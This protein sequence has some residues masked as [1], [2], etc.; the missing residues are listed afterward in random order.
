MPWG[1]RDREIG[2]LHGPKG[3]GGFRGPTVVRYDTVKVKG[4]RMALAVVRAHG[5]TF[6][7]M[8]EHGERLFHKLGNE[9]FRPSH[10]NGSVAFDVDHGCNWGHG[11]PWENREYPA[12]TW[13]YNI[14]EELRWL[15][16]QDPRE[17][18]TRHTVIRYHAD[19]CDNE[20]YEGSDEEEWT[21]R[22][23]VKPTVQEMI[24][25]RRIINDI[26]MCSR[27][28]RKKEKLC[29]EAAV[30][31]MYEKA[32]AYDGVLQSDFNEDDV[33]DLL[34][35]SSDDDRE[36]LEHLLHVDTVVGPECHVRGIPRIRIPAGWGIA[37]PAGWGIAPFLGHDVR[38]WRFRRYRYW[39]SREHY[40]NELAVQEA[41]KVSV[42]AKK[43]KRLA[44][45]RAVTY[46]PTNR[47]H[48]S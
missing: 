43:K 1:L 30:T 36:G 4:A 34:H 23:A 13:G 38:H 24:E 35:G 10:V 8:L 16:R 46:S 41:A 9:P 18:H 21:T 44:D 32:I 27:E 39:T 33:G 6:K 2:R 47:Q 11:A 12:Y 20:D 31:K 5:G 22:W 15:P 42:K 40:A 14:H 17:I 3:R 29:R 45:W 48:Q 26:Q 25:E 28:E 37:P 19:W 7:E